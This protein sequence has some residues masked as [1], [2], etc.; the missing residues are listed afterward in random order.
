M[1]MQKGLTSKQAEESRAKYGT[2]RLSEKERVTFFKKYMEKFDDPII[3][4]LLVALGINIVFTFFGKVDWF[5]C[6]GIFI[7]VMI[8][9]L[10]GAFSEYKNEEEFQ[11][12]QN[13]AAKI[14]CKVYRDSRL[15]SLPIDEIVTDDIVLLQAG[16]MIPADGVV[17]SGKI[18]VD[19]SA[20]NGENEEVE[21]TE[22]SYGTEVLTQ[23]DFWDKTA[24]YRGCIV[25]S[26][27]CEMRVVRVGD[28][29]VYGS[30]N[31]SDDD[32]NRKSPLQIKL[33]ALAKK[34]SFFGYIGSVTVA[35]ATMLQHI[36]ANGAMGVAAYF[37]DTIQFVSDLVG[38]LIMG[39]TV[40]VVAVPE[41]LPLMVAIVCS[42]NMKKMLKSNVLVR[43]LIGIETA[44][45]IN[46]LFTDKTGTITCGKLKAV[47]FT[48]G[49]GAT[50]DRFDKIETPLKKLVY[51]SSVYNSA[52]Q[53]SGEGVIGGNA[54]ER[55]L[56]DMVKSFKQS[57]NVKKSREVLFTS[58][59]KFSMTEMTGEF[60]GVLVK[61]APEKILKNCT[62]YYDLSGTKQPLSKKG[63]LE[64]TVLEMANRSIRVLALATAEDVI[65]DDLPEELT[66]VGLVGIRDDLRPDVKMAV[67]D[68]RRAGIQTVMIT[69][70]KKETALAIARE[71]GIVEDEGVVITSDEM[72]KMT[73][74]QLA[75]VM[76]KLRVVAR[77]LPGDKSR[78][79]RIAQKIG[80]VTGM[81]GDGVNDLAALRASDVGFAMGSGTDIAKEAG[82]IVIL[83]D[84]F[85]SIKK[86]VLYG[87][88]IY[89]SIKKFVAFQITINI[90]AM[91]V[92]VL[93]P[94][95]GVAKPLGVIQ[96][97]WVNL[98]M[99]T[100]AAIAFGGEAALGR[101][102]LEKP[103]KRDEDIIDRKMW[104]SVT[105]NSLFL[106]AVSVFMFISQDI[107]Y[108][109]RN[110]PQDAVF[111]TAYFN[112]FVFSCIFNAF[113]V[114]T[115]SID[116][117]DHISLN[118]PFL[119][120]LLIIGVVQILMTCFG[121]AIIGTARLAAN[122]W[123]LVIV[124]ALL[125]VPV[126][127]LRKLIVRK[128]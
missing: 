114:R 45:G 35:T 128:A 12:I 120:I 103:I 72:K 42:L 89:K 67:S 55:A 33:A 7:S 79:V 48:D 104:S 30:L 107:H 27:Q 126:D 73:D 71:A 19:Q 92:L 34:I 87:R 108:A 69:G 15:V 65:G 97:L 118:K 78:L 90:A 80:N 54:T 25:C 29:T 112:Y 60:C 18:K 111:Y 117:T 106:C 116:L 62:E 91:S 57:I 102:M 59:N 74:A 95:I 124:M 93:G 82:D 13:E 88:T 83:D 23:T 44:G 105:I 84:N 43:K 52:A 123:A 20:L 32:D 56:L 51:L 98:V 110:A 66:L 9:T 46:I 5:E 50:V 75:G 41:G 76:P 10:V 121:G 70:D 101:Y 94:I 61:G 115:E 86:A 16:D 1:D 68:M 122:E 4:I 40:I 39:I 99:D 96:M 63:Q 26:G 24:L 109:F 14:K 11:R 125:I 49:N 64:K 77:A 31:N 127:I 3:I 6:L 119:I 113:N 17:A 21:K 2:N 22:S 85:A 81:T 28:S 100:L 53:F 36:F 58:E 38:A 8:A 37:A 47:S